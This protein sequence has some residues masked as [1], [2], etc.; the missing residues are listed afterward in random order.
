MQ[1]LLGGIRGAHA[2]LKALPGFHSRISMSNKRPDS[3]ILEHAYGDGMLAGFLGLETSAACPFGGDQT[4]PRIARLEGFAYGVWKGAAKINASDQREEYGGA[5]FEVA[6]R[7]D[8]DIVNIAIA[9]LL[10]LSKVI[11]MRGEQDREL[12]SALKAVTAFIRFVQLTQA[13]RQES[14]GK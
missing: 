5:G 4:G 10:R 12:D 1:L 11:G 3:V 14:L 7:S 2:A 13:A 9:H 6:Y 8:R